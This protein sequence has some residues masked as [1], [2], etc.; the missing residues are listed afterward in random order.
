LETGHRFAV[1]EAV[2]DSWSSP[3]LLGVLVYGASAYEEWMGV[4]RDA[5]WTGAA[6]NA[7]VVGTRTST[8]S[9]AVAAAP[10]AA[11]PGR[12]FVPH[13]LPWPFNST[14]W[15]ATI[16]SLYFWSLLVLWIGTLI[17]D[18]RSMAPVSSRI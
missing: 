3:V 1:R 18:K 10:G 2:R 9:L 14:L 7:S 15:A 6:M 13:V 4:L 5:Q 12:E 17:N 11:R 16:G 8:G